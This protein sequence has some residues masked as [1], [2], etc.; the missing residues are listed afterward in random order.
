MYIQE[1]QNCENSTEIDDRKFCG[2]LRRDI[3]KKAT[4]IV[5]ERNED[6]GRKHLS[7]AWPVVFIYLPGLNYDLS[8]LLSFCICSVHTTWRNNKQSTKVK[9]PWASGKLFDRLLKL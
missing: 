8:R 7:L 3:L 9:S 1:K 4:Y 5:E 2:R 6:G